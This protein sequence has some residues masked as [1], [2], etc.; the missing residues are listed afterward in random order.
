MR[1]KKNAK[2][3]QELDAML[4]R[5]AKGVT[6][7]DI[8][9]GFSSPDALE[10]KKAARELIRK[11]A[12]FS[13]EEQPG[14]ATGF[15]EPP[16]PPD[17]C[18]AVTEY[19]P[20]LAPLIETMSVNVDSFGWH[21]NPIR[22]QEDINKDEKLKVAMKKEKAKVFNFL[23]NVHPTMSFV[24]LRTR[25]GLDRLKMGNSFWEI[26]RDS[27]GVPLR[28]EHIP[29]KQMRI[30]KLG[31]LVP[32]PFYMREVVVDDK[33]NES[34][35]VVKQTIRR[36]FRRYCLL[37][38]NG[39]PRTWFKE[40]GDP[41]KMSKATGEYGGSGQATEVIHFAG[42]SGRSVYGLPG[43]ISAMLGV[44]TDIAS[45]EVIF[46]TLRNNNVPSMLVLVSGG[47]LD[48]AS[49]DR[50]MEFQEENVNS[51]KNRSAFVI[52]NAVQEEREG[53]IMGGNDQAKPPTIHVE[54][55]NDVQMRDGMFEGLQRALAERARRV[56]RISPIYFGDVQGFNRAT[57]S[58]GRKM[59]EEQVFDPLRRRFDELMDVHFM[60]SMGVVHH[61]FRTSGPN[62]TDEKDIDSFIK[63]G[64]RSGAVT[65]RS[66]HMLLKETLG[67]DLPAPEGI[68]LDI[69]MSLQMAK[70]AQKTEGPMGQA[71][72][73]AVK[74]ISLP[75]GAT[76]DEIV[77][78]LVEVRDKLI[79]ELDGRLSDDD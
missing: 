13:D 79:E 51:R 49:I 30:A 42:Y 14:E 68:D 18:L 2:N 62:V 3:R 57:A 71:Q 1:R 45:E 66:A 28:I 67:R 72:V 43:W 75:P 23:N 59:T 63:T 33:G 44:E 15:I 70:A 41:R 5:L 6:K 7:A 16:L 9:D 32:A 35:R 74:G 24:E 19:A 60:R 64:E 47:Y 65:P 29:A 22:N 36:R 40:F 37:D 26:I 12:E 34:E 55:M 8:K 17:Y 10:A 48:Q 61:R 46:F 53:A 52:L 27:D 76:Q 54:K 50:L 11:A 39:A 21:L 56:S 4:M 25:Q 20:I 69:P 77:D 38:A 58:I 73:A 78:L 31:P